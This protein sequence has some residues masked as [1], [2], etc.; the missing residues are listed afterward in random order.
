[1]KNLRS[2]TQK[3]VPPKLANEQEAGK[4]GIY[5]DW[6]QSSLS[7]D[8]INSIYQQLLEAEEKI[9][10][11]NA[12]DL[13]LLALRLDLDQAQEINRGKEFNIIKK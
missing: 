3:L 1:M 11:Q 2:I 8:R 10:L 6:L 7:S 5:W 13:E 9:V 12:N 4:I